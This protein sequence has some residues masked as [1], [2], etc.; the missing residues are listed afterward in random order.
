MRL[1]VDHPND[2]REH[3]AVRLKLK[4]EAILNRVSRLRSRDNAWQ[5]LGGARVEFSGLQRAD[6]RQVA[7]GVSIYTFSFNALRAEHR[8]LPGVGALIVADEIGVAV[9]TSEFEVTVAGRQPGV[10]H[11]RDDY[12]TISKNQYAR[13]LF[14]AVAC[15]TLDANA[16]QLPLSHGSS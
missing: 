9:G 13:R 7:H 14:A 12:A 15:V 6:N 2:R 16:K 4:P 1:S 3:F 8:E 5:E 11:F 10:E